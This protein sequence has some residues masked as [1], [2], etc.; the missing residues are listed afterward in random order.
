MQARTSH[1]GAIPT[2]GAVSRG[3]AP[4][5]DGESL[6]QRKDLSQCQATPMNVLSRRVNA[7]DSQI[8]LMIPAT[9]RIMR[10]LPTRG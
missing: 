6:V 2:N 4:H 10:P 3:A 1:P 7:C 5:F 8:V 9:E